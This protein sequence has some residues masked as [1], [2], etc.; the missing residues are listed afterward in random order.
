MWIRQLACDEEVEVGMI[1]N[2]L[3]ANFD[4]FNTTQLERLLQE[5][6]LQSGVQLLEHVFQEHR[7]PKTDSI[8]QRPQELL[9]GQF[10]NF[11]T[12]SLVR[13]FEPLVGLALGINHQCPTA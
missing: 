6:W 1:G 10:N 12:C 9:L 13:I 7:L 2:C 4:R 8:D 3:I 11:Q 5:D